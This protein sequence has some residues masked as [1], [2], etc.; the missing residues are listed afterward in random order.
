MKSFSL[1]SSNKY[2]ARRVL[3]C[4]DCCTKAKDGEKQCAR[5]GSNRVRSFASQG[6]YERLLVLRAQEK[7]GEIRDLEIQPR[8]PII[9]EGE[10]IGTAVM[11]FAYFKGNERVVE[12]F[13]GFDT[14]LSAFKRKV[15]E[16]IYRMKVTVVR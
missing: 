12:D 11:D 5:C 4:S 16:A 6:E 9:I 3:A 7:R 8:F 14:P 10:K 13:K 1:T 15:V 2:R